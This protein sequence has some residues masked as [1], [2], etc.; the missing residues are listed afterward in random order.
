[1]PTEKTNLSPLEE[2]LFKKWVA[3]KKIGD[4]DS[5]ES[6]YDYRGYWKDIASKGDDATKM[7][8]DGLH[9]T[10]KYKQHGHPTFSR[11]HNTQPDLLMV[12]DGMKILTYRNLL[13][14]KVM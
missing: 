14:Q 10:D 11:N 9:F 6:F 1:M 12:G 3:D 5:P 2:A 7:Y 4:S 8:D 13:P